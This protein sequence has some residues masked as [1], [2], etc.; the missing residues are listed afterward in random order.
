M[1][2]NNSIV[3]VGSGYEI[4]QEEIKEGKLYLVIGDIRVPPKVSVIE[5]G[6]SFS[7]LKRD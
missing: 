2:S 5:S 1:D 4:A 6:D 3:L 7:L